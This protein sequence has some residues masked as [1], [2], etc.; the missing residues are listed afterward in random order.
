M[1]SSTSLAP[2]F[3]LT[4]APIGPIGCLV[5]RR[6]SD[7]PFIAF[8]IIRTSRGHIAA[9]VLPLKAP[10]CSTNGRVIELTAEGVGSELWQI[11]TSVECGSELEK[12]DKTR[13]RRPRVLVDVPLKRP[14]KPPACVGVIGAAQPA[15]A[16]FGVSITPVRCARAPVTG[17]RSGTKRPKRIS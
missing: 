12:L 6:F 10:Q 5:S 2:S 4:I 14:P 17:S 7:Y 16:R 13:S 1:R 15:P 11:R 9:S 8:L 3:Q